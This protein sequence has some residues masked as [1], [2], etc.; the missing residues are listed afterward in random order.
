M[1]EV[2]RG[3]SL[4]GERCMQSS[5]SRTR[6]VSKGAVISLALVL[7]GCLVQENKGT[8]EGRVGNPVSIPPDFT[9]NPPPGSTNT[10]QGA[11]STPVQPPQVPTFGLRINSGDALT[12]ANLLQIQIFSPIRARM[13][14]SE[15]SIC[16]DGQWEP[17]RE[18]VELPVHALNQRVDLSVQFQD[19]E[20]M[21]STCHTASIVHDD[22][23]PEILFSRY[24]LASIEEGS[25]A[26]LIYDVTDTAIVSDVKCR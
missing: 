14:I 6:L 2:E 26:E 25:G 23:G 13:K 20:G 15:N 9:F 11:I 19:F 8:T 4:L 17:F 24:P 12:K 3:M 7:A 21:T 18:F 1:D 16:E 5:P 10:G 22:K